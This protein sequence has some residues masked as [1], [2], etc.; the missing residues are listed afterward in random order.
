MVR[1]RTLAATLMVTA[2]AGAGL[3]SRTAEREAAP[4]LRLVLNAAAY[5]LDVYEGGE[6]TRSYTVAVGMPGH[7]TPSG[8]FRISKIIWN[9]WWNPP[10]RAWARDAQRTPP[11]PGNPMGRVKMYFRNLYF[12]HGTP[13]EAS[14]GSAASHGCV[15]MANE[16]AIELARLVHRYG[17]PEVSRST[18]DGLV[19]DSRDTR[20]IHL[21]RPIPLEIVY[22]GAAAARPEPLELL[23]TAVDSDR[24]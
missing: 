22:G 1:V 8:S 11:G 21:A 16:D 19:E 17:S 2:L 18:I 13:N 20:T 9:P 4:G 7:R 10:S 5:R 15:R 24:R 23:G 6:R 14:L 3:D 12:I